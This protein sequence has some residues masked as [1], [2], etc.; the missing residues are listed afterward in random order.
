M[1]VSSSGATQRVRLIVTGDLERVALRSSLSSLFPSAR[2]NGAPVEWLRPRKVSCATSHRLVRG[3]PTSR[4]MLRLAA[5]LVAE[6]WEGAD[7]TPADLVVAVDDLVIGNLG[8]SAVVCEH[9]RRAIDTV[10]LERQLA[11]ATEARLR[12]RLQASCSFH[13]LAPMAES[14]FFGEHAALV[15]AGCRPDVRPHLT[16][17]EDVERFECSDPA[18]LPTCLEINQARIT[19]RSPVPWWREERHPKHY[20]EHLVREAGGF[21]D[22]LLGGKAGLETLAWATVGAAPG[23]IPLARALLE[24][25]ADFFGC[26]NPLGAGLPVAPTYPARTARRSRLRLRNL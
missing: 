8:Q 17:P 23:S 7:G 1:P 11:A 15:R 13:L 16:Q 3:A 20:L 10:I 26:P 25:L 4:A 5:A 18:W 12:S 6:A 19:S 2:A 9:V 21:Y 24:D 14:Y 22:E